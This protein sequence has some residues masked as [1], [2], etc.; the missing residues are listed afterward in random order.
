MTRKLF[1]GVDGGASKTAAVVVDEKLKTL[2]EGRSGP[3]NHLFLC[4]RSTP[5]PVCYGRSIGAEE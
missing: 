3:S 2:G 1:I 5:T 4:Y